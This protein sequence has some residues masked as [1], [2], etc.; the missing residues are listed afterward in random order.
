MLACEP[1]RIVL[2]SLHS[3]I[4]T[5][6]PQTCKRLQVP[7]AAVVYQKVSDIAWPKYIYGRS[8]PGIICGLSIS[9]RY[10]G[11]YTNQ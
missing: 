9:R 1:A 7:A 6:S 2:G 3:S 10:S 4:V 5:A 11:P 8:P